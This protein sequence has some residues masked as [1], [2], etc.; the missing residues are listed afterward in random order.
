[1]L[2]VDSQKMLAA[3]WAA[4]QVQDGMVVG[5]GSGSTAALAIRA[6]GERVRQGLKIIGVATSIST[7]NLALSFRMEVWPLEACRKVDIAIDGADEVDPRL[8]LIKG[9]GGAL[10]RE[11]SV[12]RVSGSRSSRRRG[13][14]AGGTR[15]RL[16]GGCVRSVGRRCVS[17]ARRAA[18]APSRKPRTAAA[19]AGGNCG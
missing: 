4:N 17:P 1:M 14:G 16:T 19:S 9:L 12:F 7:E 15:S 5:L 10:L 8:N 13:R 2:D 18:V 11:R 6:L 3:R